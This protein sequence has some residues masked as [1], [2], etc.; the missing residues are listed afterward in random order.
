VLQ[1]LIEEARTLERMST[2]EIERGRFLETEA[3]SRAKIMGQKIETTKTRRD[4]AST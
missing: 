3:E 4:A 2:S 1:T